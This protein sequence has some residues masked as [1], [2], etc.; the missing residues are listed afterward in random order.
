MA[1]RVVNRHYD[2]ALAPIGITTTQYAILSRIA[3]EGG[4]PLGVL[5]GRLALDRTTLSR[6][7]KPL[8]AA[9]LLGE[10][11][12]ASD[13][14]RRVVRLTPRGRGILRRAGPLW[15]RAQSELTASFGDARTGRLLS[16][17]QALVGAE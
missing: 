1:A 3:R 5:A 11:R 8:V 6:E 4:Q 14:R 12:D 10:A 17:L 15:S 7:L 13:A 2:R 16:E 9:G